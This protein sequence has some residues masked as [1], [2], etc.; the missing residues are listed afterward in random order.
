M[1]LCLESSCWLLLLILRHIERLVLLLVLEAKYLGWE[2]STTHGW[3]G[4]L[5][6]SLSTSAI[7]CILLIYI[8]SFNAGVEVILLLH[9]NSITIALDNLQMVIWRHKSQQRQLVRLMF[10]VPE[11][12]Y[13]ELS[14]PFLVFHRGSRWFSRRT[15]VLSRWTWLW[16]RSFLGAT[17]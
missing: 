8:F 6:H 3:D 5:L 4:T 13:S 1:S 12:L 15:R 14:L 10:L 17:V 11:L 7:S 9:L 2:Q 16:G